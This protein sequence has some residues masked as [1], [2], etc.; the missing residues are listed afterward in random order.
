MTQQTTDPRLELANPGAYIKR[1]TDLAGDQD[2]FEIL[3]ATPTA[4]ERLIEANPADRLRRRPFENKWTPLE[5]IGHLHDTEWV[6]GYR[7][8][9]IF[10]DDA[11]ELVG[12]DQDRWADRL[13]HNDRRPAELVAD[14]RALR[15]INLRFWRT[16]P[17]DELSR[18]G[19]HRERGDESLEL[20]TKLAAGHD[21]WHLDQIKRYLAALPG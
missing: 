7:T 20:M 10:C 11:P 9:T 21:L 3:T 1:L 14:F 2:R 13:R 18:V 15:Q 4:L 19:R 8:R 17:D 16:I 12:M 6:F 5:I